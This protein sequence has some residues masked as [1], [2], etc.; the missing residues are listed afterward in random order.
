MSINA[1]YTPRYKANFS[2]PLLLKLIKSCDKFPLGFIYKAAFLLAYFAFLRLSNIASSSSTSFDPTRHFLRGD[3]I[4]GPPGAHVI[5]KW[6]KAMQGSTKHQVIQIPSLPSSPLCP[7]SA[8]TSLLQ[9]IT[10]PSSAPHFLS[11]PPSS[12]PITAPMIS[13]TLSRLLS[14]IGL[15]PSYYG[16][17]AFRRSAV[18]WAADNDVPLQNLKAHG[19]WSSSAINVYLKHTPKAASTVATTFQKIFTT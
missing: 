15:N 10:A 17:H 3:I 5:V 18:S 13:A 7:V 14:S 11:P 1:P 8:L 4:F 6:A 16:F 12:R 9:S 19:G 2:I